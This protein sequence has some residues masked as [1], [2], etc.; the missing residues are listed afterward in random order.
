MLKDLK[1]EIEQYHISFKF[2]I[3]NLLWA[4]QFDPYFL[5][6]FYYRIGPS[7][8]TLCRLLKKDNSTFSIICDKLGS[9][10]MFHPFAT[11]INAKEI[12]NNLTI[13]NGT[14]I[15]NIHNNNNLRPIIGRNVEIGANVSIIGNIHI[16]NNVVIGAGAVINK[17]VPDNAVVVGNPFRI[18]RYNE[19]S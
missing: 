17:D 8:A 15:G 18:I 10:T 4:L 16:G 12:G 19:N 1:K 7:K 13:R 5:S 9:V 3:L 14:T 11:I 6:L 2:K